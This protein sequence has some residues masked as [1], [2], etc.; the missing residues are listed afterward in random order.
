MVVLITSCKG[1]PPPKEEQKT[2]IVQ[3]NIPKDFALDKRDENKFVAKKHQ[4]FSAIEKKLRVKF[5]D[6]EQ[7]KVIFLFDDAGN[8]IF[9]EYVIR[10]P[11]REPLDSA[12][13]KEALFHDDQEGE[14]QFPIKT[15]MRIFWDVWAKDRKDAIHILF[16]HEQNLG[17]AQSDGGELLV[18]N[19]ENVAK[20]VFK[21][22][23]LPYKRQLD[24]DGDFIKY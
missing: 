23:K 3:Q 9:K 4:V 15:G 6:L 5:Q 12:F 11:N 1:M 2:D 17:T 16:I 8:Q 14:W 13:V 20:N 10:K 22:Y 24:Q 7:I 18:K 21:K 19:F